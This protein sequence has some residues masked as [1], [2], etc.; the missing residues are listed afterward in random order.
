[1]R[2]APLALAAFAVCSAAGEPDEPAA[3]V[4]D[5]PLE[6]SV[7]P[8]RFQ[9]PTLLW[10]DPV[11]EADAWLVSFAVEGAAERF[12]ALTD[13]PPAPAGEIDPRALS[14]T[15]ALYEPTPYQAS[16]RSF[17]PDDERW[18][19]LAQASSGRT[20]RVRLL[21]FRR[22]DPARVLS[23]GEVAITIS[24]DPVDGV[25]FYRDVPLMPAPGSEGIIRPLAQSALPLIQWRVRDLARSESRVVLEDMR[26]CA[27]CHSF[28]SD[29]RTMGI[30]V[31][32]PTG[33]KGSY[34]VASVEP[35]TVIGNEQVITWNAAEGKLPGLNT[36][37]F[38]SR[39]SPDGR[40]VV[41]TV[42]EQIYVANFKDYR[43]GQVFYPTRGVLAVYSRETGRIRMLPG[44]DD[45]RFVHCDP[46]WSPDG[47]FIVF[48]RAEAREAYPSGRPLATYAGDPQE[49]PI[50]Y[51]LYRMP[52]EGGR[53]GPP[54]PIRGASANGTSN[55]FPKITPDGRFVVF[56][57][58]ANGQLMRPDS[59]LWIVPVEGGEPRRMT[60]NTT[61]MN[62]WHSFSPNGRWM[63]FSSK[64][65]TPYTQMFLTHLDEQGRDTPAVLVPNSTAAN[66]AVN[67]PE[68]VALDF[69]GLQR[70]RVPAVEHQRYFQLGTDLA[71]A[72]RYAEAVEQFELALAGEPQAWRTNDW[73]IHESLAKSLL[74]IGQ[75]D[76]A[77][78]HTQQSLALHP[79][80][81]EMHTNL[82]FIYAERG[83][84]LSALEHLET[85]LRL[86]PTFPES[87]YNRG[88]L[89]LGLG[90]PGE[91]RA[92][93]D[94]AIRR[95]PRYA[96]AYLGR[97][98]IRQAEGDLTGALGDFDAAVRLRPN[99]PDGWY[100]RG[101]ARRA[102]GDLAGAR[103]DLARAEQAAPAS[104][105]YRRELEAALEELGVALRQGV[106]TAP[107]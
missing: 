79:Q 31:D 48:A 70:I 102:A 59:E 88:T 84:A 94:E 40:H 72:G 53:G 100:R 19:A 95:E 90:R 57:R 65:N 25:V 44:A 24:S 1:M 20:L 69:E 32:G 41:S 28:S 8:Q 81:A 29:G 83:D 89:L 16:A 107:R 78:E 34:A 22:D 50:R 6:G 80:N 91:A 47:R 67:I 9:P 99:H 63:V 4:V 75:L 61:R 54:E 11:A 98:A 3:I 18:A 30:D 101:L 93:F 49:L 87:W 36:L 66:R 17:R 52:F 71:Q 105:V 38:L 5:Y 23:R 2:I 7:F 26:T 103:E 58:C 60:C 104:W 73:R 33:D 21:G 43:F 13:G 68:F 92:D 45:P 12:D 56:V 106:Q 76:R 35:E 15:N 55:N 51:D 10:H 62:S 37:G 46:V 97:G 86:A 64:S 27:N 82:A 14:E 74:R 96:D 85:A 39:V 42:N 77:L